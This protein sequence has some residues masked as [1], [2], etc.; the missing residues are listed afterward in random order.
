VHRNVRNISSFMAAADLALSSAGRTVFELIACQ[1]PVLV[2]A[3]NERE[4][5]HTCADEAHGVTSL[6]L[7]SDLTEAQVAQAIRALLP[8]EARAA[9]RACMAAVDLWSGP[10]RIMTAVLGL[11]RARRLRDRA[12]RAQRGLR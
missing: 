5:T 12:L 11:L 3:Q 2:L 6:G 4:L 7:G 10:D 1:T 8:K 9:A